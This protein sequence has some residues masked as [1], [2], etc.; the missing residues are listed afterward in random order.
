ML[1]RNAS[2]RRLA[3]VLAVALGLLVQGFVPPP[4]VATPAANPLWALGGICGPGHASDGPDSP[5]QALGH[6][7]CA[8]CQLWPTAFVLP[9]P[10]EPPVP[11]PALILRIRAAGQAPHFTRARL[12]YASRAPPHA[13]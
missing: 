10:P 5:L 6:R 8:Y 2:L 7:H 4:A 13:G 3:V 11:R 1:V 9:G 12:A